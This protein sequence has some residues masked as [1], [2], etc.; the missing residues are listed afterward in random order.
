MDRILAL[1]SPALGI[2]IIGLLCGLPLV[3]WIVLHY[4]VPE[5]LPADY[6][7]PVEQEPEPMRKKD[8]GVIKRAQIGL[9]VVEVVEEVAWPVRLPV[10]RRRRVIEC[11]GYVTSAKDAEALADTIRA[12]ASEV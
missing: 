4:F 7:A 8:R 2:L 6:P 10:L 1:P 3:A 9:A 12:Y 5:Y 11:Y